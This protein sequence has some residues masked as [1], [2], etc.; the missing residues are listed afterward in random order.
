MNSSQVLKFCGNCN[1]LC[2]TLGFARLIFK[3]GG[4]PVTFIAKYS[5]ATLSTLFQDLAAK[6]KSQLD[7][8]R[9]TKEL[10]ESQAKESGPTNQRTEE[11][12]VL[13]RTDA[14]G[15]VRPLEVTTEREHVRGRKKRQKV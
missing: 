2:E 5:T 12:V 9:R 13:T 14:A 1:Y 6:L 7:E 15:N 8:M 11:T 4:V 3:R 10:Q